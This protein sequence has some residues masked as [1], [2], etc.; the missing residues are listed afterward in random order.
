MRKLFFRMLLGC[1][2]EAS[3]FP[4]TLIYVAQEKW[5]LY[6]VPTADSVSSPKM[7]LSPCETHFCVGKYCGPGEIDGCSQ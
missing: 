2:L 1:T 4:Y 5:L 3:R 6:F 7:E